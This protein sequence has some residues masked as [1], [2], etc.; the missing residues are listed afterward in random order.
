MSSHFFA[1]LETSPTED[2][3]GEIFQDV[4][5]A[6]ALLLLIGGAL[7]LIVLLLRFAAKVNAF[8]QDKA[9]SS[10]ES[11]NRQEALEKLSST[12]DIQIEIKAQNYQSVSVE[13][14]IPVAMSQSLQQDHAK[15]LMIRL[16]DV[17]QIDLSTQLP[18]A[19]Y[20]YPCDWG[21][22]DKVQVMGIAVVQGDRDYIAELGYM[23]VDR[24]WQQLARSTH[25]RVA[26]AV[27]SS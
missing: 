9:R 12:S 24:R 15:A 17:T 10:S 8:P 2:V 7:L 22:D 16:L 21:Q 6:I 23:T 1:Q 27:S 20:D 4:M 18:H 5:P 3:V 26:A 14:R 11:G 25:V 19:I 13:W